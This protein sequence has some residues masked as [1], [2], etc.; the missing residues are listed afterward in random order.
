MYKTLFFGVVLVVIL[1]CLYRY[2]KLK[3]GYK[4]PYIWMNNICKRSPEGMLDL[5]SNNAI[6]LATYSNSI[7]RGK[8][9]LLEYFEE[10]L[11]KDGLCGEITSN[12]TQQRGNTLIN[13]GTYSFL[14]YE[15]GETM[16][17]E[18]RYTFVYKL[19]NG[20]WKVINHHS[21]VNPD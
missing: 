5:Y 13:S 6:L 8:E 3:E 21:S 9:E 17:V 19:C 12:Y 4:L 7:L 2:R 14:F 16:E 15:N 18:A 11:S 1:C 10:F 20:E